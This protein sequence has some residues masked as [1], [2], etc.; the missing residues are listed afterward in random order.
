MK[1]QTQESVVLRKLKRDGKI[2][3]LWA[4]QNR[5][6][7]LSAVVFNLRAEGHRIDTV[8]NRDGIGRNTMYV[9]RDRA[10]A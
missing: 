1:K 9:L 6:W 2:R 7:R 5:I 10:N 3:N 8:Y 4:I